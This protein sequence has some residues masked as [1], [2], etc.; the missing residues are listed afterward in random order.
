MSNLK[1]QTWGWFLQRIT[2]IFLMVGLLVHFWVVHFV[3]ERPL[4]FEKVFNRI[5]S[6]VLWSVFDLLLLAAALFHAL[7]GIWGIFKDYNPSEKW[8][9]RVYWA[10]WV[11]GIISLYVGVKIMLGLTI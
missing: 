7:N 4:D 3:I 9:K 11:V 8:N 1:V 6:S 2:A 10:L 5:T